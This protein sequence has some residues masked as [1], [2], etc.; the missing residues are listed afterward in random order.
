MLQKSG[1]S[2]GEPLGP[3]FARRA[4]GKEPEK[5]RMP[6]AKSAKPEEGRTVIKTEQREIKVGDDGEISEVRD[7]DV[8]DLTFSDS[9][10]GEEE[11]KEETEENEEAVEEAM[12]Q[13]AEVDT[14]FSSHNSTALITP[15]PTVLKSDRLGVGLK[16]KTVGP[17]KESKKRV[18]H[19][20]AALA[21]HIRSAEEMR[22]MKKRWGR[23][24][25][26]LARLA[27]AEA[28]HRQS[29]LADLKG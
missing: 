14:T 21:A 4:K 5:P 6:K 3:G 15:L 27:K 16:A 28:E 22:K 10:E 12:E 17:Y 13:A 23:G 8:I 1:W 7:V 24:T 19:N 9:E 11:L 26:G 29:L 25:R 2:E 18:T 20:A